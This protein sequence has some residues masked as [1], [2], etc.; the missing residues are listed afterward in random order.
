MTTVCLRTP[1]DD[2]LEIHTLGGVVE[3]PH[4]LVLHGLE[5]SPDSHYIGGLM[6]Q[7][8]ARSWNAHLVVFRGC[9][10]VVN[11][12]KRFY[13]SGETSDL[14][15]A[16]HE[17]ASRSPDSRWLMVG[18]SL[19]GNVLLKWLGEMSASLDS[20][21]AA[22]VAISTPFDLE[23]GAKHIGRGPLHVYDRSFLRSLRRKARAKLVRFPILF[24][25]D[26]A[27]RAQTLFDFD[28]AVTAPVHGFASAHDYY[29][30]SSSLQFLPRIRVRTL[31]LSSQDD[32]FLPREVLVRASAAARD[33][34]A[35]RTEFLPT[36][37]H[38]GFVSGPPWRPV[39]YAE[40]RA[41]QFFDDAMERR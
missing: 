37:G 35:V 17:L 39:Y 13:H 4:V 19:G 11:I 36:G 8:A 40:R 9:G 31:L 7:A 12:T 16:F 38:V 21:I 29:E 15:F 18:V 23:A 2:N 27:E 10:T 14:D 34:P 26:R 33:N 28:D 25:R 5:G 32:P 1:D 22:A 41:F 24:D 30:K 20:R 6:A 3:S